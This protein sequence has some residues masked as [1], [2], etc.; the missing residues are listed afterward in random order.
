[1]RVEHARIAE[2]LRAQECSSSTFMSTLS[3]VSLTCPL[4]RKIAHLEQTIENLRTQLA[5]SQRK[6]DEKDSLIKDLHAVLHAHEQQH[7]CEALYSQGRMHD[8][9]ESLIK[10]SFTGNNE[11][12][13][14][15]RITDWVTGEFCVGG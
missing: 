7:H 6:V 9:A 5:D 3:H 2:S 15:I 10:I 1:M 8:A 4:D 12:G 14:N 13:A 11:V